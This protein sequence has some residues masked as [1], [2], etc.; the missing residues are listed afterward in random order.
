[1][2]LRRLCLEFERGGPN[3]VVDEICV[4]DI[5]GA[6]HAPY[7]RQPVNESPARSLTHATSCVSIIAVTFRPAMPPVTCSQR[8]DERGL[9][10]FPILLVVKSNPRLACLMPKSSQSSAHLATQFPHDLCRW[11]G[12]LPPETGRREGRSECGK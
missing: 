11:Y 5:F 12:R 6:P 1:M 2:V 8:P 4:I 3:R 10:R 9:S 7:E